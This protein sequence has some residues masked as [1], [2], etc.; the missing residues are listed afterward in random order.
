MNKLTVEL[1]EYANQLG[2]DFT[3]IASIERFRDAPL[4]MSPAGI[5]PSAKSVIVCGIHHLDAAVELCGE[6]TP[7]DTGAYGTQSSYMNPK[8]DDISFF[9]TRFLENRGYKTVGI[10]SSNIWRYRGYKEMKI[11]F[12]PDI[13]HR[14]AAVAAGLGEI[15]WS[16]LFLHPEFGPRVRLVSIITEADLVPDPMYTGEKLCDRCM[17]C[18]KNCPV[19]AFRK[20]VKKINCIDIGGKKFCFPDINKWRCAWAENFGLNL[21]LKIPEKID[22]KVIRK[23]IEKYGSFAGEIGYCLR[24]C[25]VPEKRYYDTNYSPAPRRKKKK[26]KISIREIEKIASKYQI[27]LFCVKDS[28]ESKKFIDP[29]QHLPGCET[30]I[31]LGLQKPKDLD[32]NFTDI[33]KQRILNYA[34]FEIAHYFDLKGYS[35]I[36]QTNIDNNLVAHSLKIWKPQT[37]YSTV[38]IDTKIKN[39]TFIRKPPKEKIEKEKFRNFCMVQGA[40]LVGFFHCSRFEEFKEI[41]LKNFPLTKESEIVYDTSGLYGKYSPAVKKEKITLKEPENYLEKPG[42]III[43]G[44]HFPDT[45]VDIAKITPAETIGPYAFVQFE[46]LNI[47]S[48]I[49]YR[50]IKKLNDCGYRA[51]ISFDLTGLASKVISSRGFL[52]D[53]RSNSFAGMLAGLGFIAKNGCLMSKSFGLRQRLVAIITDFG[54]PSDPLVEE[55]NICQDCEICVRSCPVSAIRGYSRILKIE[56]H[57]F[58]IPEIDQFSCDW[59]KRYALVGKEGPTYM[60]VDINFRISKAKTEELI[61]KLLKAKFG[62][63]KRHLNICEECIRTCPFKGIRRKKC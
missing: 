3:G 63:Q 14:Y 56:K 6:P 35:A 49:A 48:D 29:E 19:D 43:I 25:M 27:D 54:F 53:M 55:K 32:A 12:A 51:N 16:G 2:A 11:H 45:P 58:E 5:L 24:F 59:A 15:G 60:G 21:A 31:C 7:H 39:F 40:D 61:D 50:V 17:E 47:L 38:L 33:I 26:K 10:V 30:I 36:T 9:I 41:Y 42:S 46:A 37:I 52:P 8:L 44:V 34:S 57:E 13:A 20:E 1:K 4:R 62:V 28:Y 22:E 23:A 18:V